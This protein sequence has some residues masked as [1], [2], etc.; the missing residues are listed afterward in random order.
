MIKLKQYSTFGAGKA[1]AKK[2]RV[3]S[4]FAWIGLLF[5]HL[6]GNAQ[7]LK[8]REAALIFPLDTFQQVLTAKVDVVEE[9]D[10]ILSRAYSSEKRLIHIT[11]ADGKEAPTWDSSR[12]FMEYPLTI[13]N[14][15]LIIEYKL[16]PNKEKEYYSVGVAF[17]RNGIPLEPRPENLRGSLGRRI[18]VQ[19]GDTLRRIT[20]VDLLEN[21]VN[22]DDTLT[23][24]L[25]IVQ[26]GL[27]PGC[28]DVPCHLGL[29]DIDR[30][31]F[32]IAGAVGVGLI[33][34]GQIFDRRS[35]DRYE[36]YANLKPSE[37]P[38]V[39][40]ESLYQDAN[41]KHHTYLGL[42]YAGLAVLTVDAVWWLV[43]E[44]QVRR[45]RR[46][47]RQ[48]CRESAFQWQPVM[49]LSDGYAAG[50][51]GVKLRVKF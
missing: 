22:L 43:K 11:A 38:E 37:N 23:V 31:P 33:G 17:Q 10:T 47:Y 15:D 2:I 12:Y 13:E 50:Q 25:T 6:H 48:C 45:D 35:D 1:E 46:Q 7:D 42:T 51:V 39:E 32:I 34:I 44:L 16:P 29:P 5:L 21:Y 40:P 4:G 49:D 27:I 14:G 18:I 9:M 30:T 41:G 3:W 8:Q 26:N 24:T 19:K 36:E 28:L 20:W